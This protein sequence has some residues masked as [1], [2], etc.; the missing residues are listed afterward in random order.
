MPFAAALS[1]HPVTAHAVGEVAGQVLE[2]IGPVPDLALLFVTPP[3]AGALEDAAGAVRSVLGPA[4]LVGCA[5]VSVVA[6]GREVEERP[7]VALWAGRVGPVAPVH[8]VAEPSVSDEPAIAGWPDEL[9]FTP[10]A[11]LLVADPF[12]FPAESL[13][14]LVQE[15]HPGLPVIGGMASAARGPGG[16]RLALDARVVT[17]GAVGA[18]LGPGVEVE[19]VVS[20]GCRPIG[21]PFAVTRVDRNIVYELAGRPAFE[22]L[23]ELARTDL[24]EEEVEL[25]NAGALHVGRVIDEHKPAFERGDFLVRNVLGADQTQGAIAVNDLVDLGATLQFHLRD[26]KSADED[27]RQLLAGRRGQADGG[28]LF[29][30]NGRGRRFF[31]EPDHDAAVVASYLDDPPV[32]GFFAAGEFGPVGGRNFVHGFTASIALLREHTG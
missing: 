29:T 3:H 20:Q 22:R 30:C 19:T 4:T 8:M 12:S 31:G 32:A 7:A 14:A 28:L 25:I 11:L 9:P 15:R 10:H 16:N 26:A 5:A 2:K 1:E 27:L 6:N 24:S 17:A 21:T 18:F 13:F 23:L